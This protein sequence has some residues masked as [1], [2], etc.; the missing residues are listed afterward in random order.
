MSVN[1]SR[2]ASEGGDVW[3]GDGVKDNN[4][5]FQLLDVGSVGQVLF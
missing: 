2:G 3:N 4:Y 1:C 5:Q